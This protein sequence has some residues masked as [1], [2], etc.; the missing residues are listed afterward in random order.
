MVIYHAMTYFNRSQVFK[1]PLHG[2]TAA[3]T[4]SLLAI[5]EGGGEIKLLIC[6]DYFRI[7]LTFQ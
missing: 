5:E 3:G 2:K 7:Q 4:G 1:H 6:V